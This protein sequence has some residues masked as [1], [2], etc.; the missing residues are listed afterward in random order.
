MNKHRII[1]MFVLPALIFAATAVLVVAHRRLQPYYAALEA[2]S[3]RFQGGLS[4]L[5]R[6]LFHQPCFV[7]NFLGYDFSVTYMADHGRV[8]GLTIA[9]KVRSSSKLKIFMY[10]RNPGTVLFAEKIEIGGHDFENY[11]I[12]SNF[13]ED[14]K[15]YFA[16]DS[17]RNIIKQLVSDGWQPPRITGSSITTHASDNR[18]KPDLEPSLVE[19]TLRNLIA[20]RIE[21]M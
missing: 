19:T 18:P 21:H 1:L 15:N 5:Q 7:G 8:F 17:R 10:D 9:C 4:K 3:K 6:F 2:L 14:A 16:D 13:P 20:L 12:Y 11:C